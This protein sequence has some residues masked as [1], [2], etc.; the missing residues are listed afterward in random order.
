MGTVV[1]PFTKDNNNKYEYIISNLCTLS[2][3]SLSD[4]LYLE[5]EQIIIHKQKTFSSFVRWWYSYNRKETCEFIVNLFSEVDSLVSILNFIINNMKHKKKKKKKKK[6]YN[7]LVNKREVLMNEISR[8]KI[9]LTNLMLTYSNDTE[10]CKNI[11]IILER[12]RGVISYK[13][14]DN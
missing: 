6:K 10:F 1:H 8:A 9:G 7:T 2:N 3:I 5:N 4:K 12:Y 14:K 11:N 13:L